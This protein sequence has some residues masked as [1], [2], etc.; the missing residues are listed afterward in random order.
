LSG[1]DVGN[2]IAEE[3]VQIAGPITCSLARG[4]GDQAEAGD[5]ICAFLSLGDPDG[6]AAIGIKEFWEPI[7][8]LGTIRFSRYPSRFSVRYLNMELRITFLL[9]ALYAVDKKIGPAFFI[10][11]NPL[12]GFDWLGIVALTVTFSVL[13]AGPASFSV[14]D[15]KLLSS[16]N[17]TKSIAPRPLPLQP[18]Q[19]KS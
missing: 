13:G 4:R 2:T 7:R 11:V 5:S 15:M 6:F 18:R 12:S 17:M 14:A 1:E 9:A 3:L 16:R 10:S 8:N 19:L